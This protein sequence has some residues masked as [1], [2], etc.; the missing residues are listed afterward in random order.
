MYTLYFQFDVVY[1]I[2]DTTDHGIWETSYEQ[3]NELN[4]YFIEK[5]RKSF[6]DDVLIV[7]VIGN[8]ESQPTNQ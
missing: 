3:I 5:M 1:Y 4:L 8:H 7:P 6:G 2:G